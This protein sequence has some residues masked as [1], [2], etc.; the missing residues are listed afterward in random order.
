[1]LYLNTLISDT[2]KELIP[3]G[4]NRDSDFVPYDYS[5]QM[6]T[7]RKK[8]SLRDIF[9]DCETLKNK[10]YLDVTELKNNLSHDLTEK[11]QMDYMV[12]FSI[13]Y[14]FIPYTKCIYTTC[15]LDFSNYELVKEIF[16]DGLFEDPKYSKYINNYS[17]NMIKNGIVIKNDFEIEQKAWN[18]VSVISGATDMDIRIGATYKVEHIAARFFPI[19][20][21]KQ[22]ILKSLKNDISKAYEKIKLKEKVDHNAILL[23][24]KE[25]YIDFLNID[26]EDTAW[27][28]D[29]KKNEHYDE[30]CELLNI[31]LLNEE[32]LSKLKIYEDLVKTEVNQKNIA[33]ADTL[34]TIQI[35]SIVLTVVG[36]A[37]VILQHDLPSRTIIYL[38]AI[39]LCSIVSISVAVIIKKVIDK[40]S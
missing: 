3:L 32:Y 2:T 7:L 13:N 31:N 18:Y 39:L 24:L 1:M 23:N 38:F 26:S 16:E 27:Q 17:V 35:A 8:C 10:K 14:S 20:V 11:G 40:K 21:A 30:I 33:L 22:N 9:K 34:N 5:S 12:D 4:F 19:V 15:I 37:L 6:Y 36:W 25:R 29:G 28:S